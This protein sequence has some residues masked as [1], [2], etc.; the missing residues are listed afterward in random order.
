MKHNQITVGAIDLH[1]VEVGS[2]PPVLFCHGFPDVWIGWRRQMEA[3]AEAGYRAMAIDMRGYGRSS[4]PDDPLAYTPL[5]A[6]GDLVG[7]LDALGLPHAV[8]V[9]HD[10]G[11]SAA[12]NAALLRP[13]RFSAVFA[14][15]VPFLTPGGPSLFEALE[16]AGTAENFYMFR[17]REPDAAEDW[18][19]AAT[20]YPSF[21]Y[22]SSGSPPPEDRW[23]PFDGE[24]GMWR[25]APVDRPDWADL[26]DIAYGV[27]EFERT[28]FRKPLNSYHS[29]QLF[30]D[31]S[32]AFAG[33]KVE[34]PALFL[35]G[36]ADG[37]TRIRDFDEDTLGPE[38][39]GLRSAVKLPEIGHWPHREAPDETNKL[40]VAFLDEVHEAA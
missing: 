2:G 39:P 7:L 5:H 37:I 30:S 35:W 26:H 15:S 28:G 27:A 40:L 25:R 19:D 13:D 21:L 34:V 6:I 11:A 23:D 32:R 33:M 4:G 9:G 17:Q 16:A 29:M 22:W 1:V 18:A 31:V 36:A 24:R 12:W 10:F 3:V 20:S 38:V 8:I 14:I